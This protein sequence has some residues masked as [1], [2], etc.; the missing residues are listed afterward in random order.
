M[1]SYLSYALWWTL[2]LLSSKNNM[3]VADDADDDDG[4]QEDVSFTVCEDTAVIVNHISILCDSPGTYYYGSGKYRNSQKCQGGDK[5]KLEV[6]LVV[7]D[8]LEEPAYLTMYVVG[9]GT[10]ENVELYS[11]ENLCSLD[12]FSSSCGSDGFLP[13]PGNYYIKQQFH[14]GSKNDQYEYSFH[15]KVVV[16]LQSNINKNKYDLGGANTDWCDGDTFTRWTAGVRKSAANTLKTFLATFGIL[17]G[18]I[19][20]VLIGG[21][22]IMRTANRPAATNTTTIS[23]KNLAKTLLE[24]EKE[25]E[26]KNEANK[27]RLVGENKDLVEVL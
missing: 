15:P 17:T 4:Q 27:S 8:E 3:A 22:C 26:K 20:T 2:F 5:A 18:A 14:W 1:R 9:Y 13:A 19:L 23:N 21:W 11:A 10:V 25:E 16:G 24:N 12:S 6:E 7:T